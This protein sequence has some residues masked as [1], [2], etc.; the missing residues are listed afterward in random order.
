MVMSY[1][2]HYDNKDPQKYRKTCVCLWS[3]CLI[4][5]WRGVRINWLSLSHELV[6]L[7]KITG[8]FIYSIIH[9]NSMLN[10]TV[11]N[12]P[13][14]KYHLNVQLPLWGFIVSFSSL[15]SC[16][17]SVSQLSQEHYFVCSRNQFLSFKKPTLHNTLCT[18]WQTVTAGNYGRGFQGKCCLIVAGNFSTITRLFK[19]RLFVLSFPCSS[20]GLYWTCVDKIGP[21]AFYHSLIFFKKGK[22]RQLFQGLQCTIPCGIMLFPGVFPSGVGGDQKQS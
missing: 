1:W 20:M 5:H 3:V 4:S 6:I 22:K 8:H 17:G 2:I 13:A 9:L 21:H 16:F 18:K 19:V 11:P 14:E 15:C 10:Y 7:I 12:E